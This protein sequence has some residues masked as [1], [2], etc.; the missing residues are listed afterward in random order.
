[1]S[2]LPAGYDNEP[3]GTALCLGVFDGV[4][5]GHQALVD[6]CVEAA[7][8]R[9]LM[10]QALSFDPHPAAFFGKTGA[11][12]LL[13]LPSRRAELLRDLGLAN[14]I[15]ARFDQAFSQQTPEQF[16]DWLANDLQAQLVVTGPDYR[17]GQ[18]RLGTIKTLQQL[19][20]NRFDTLVVDEVGGEGLRYRSSE[21]RQALQ[22]GDLAR[23]RLLTGRDFDFSGVVVAGQGRGRSLGFATANLEVD[24]RQMLPAD[25]VY[26]LRVESREIR[27]DGVMNLGRAPT[28]RGEQGQRIPEVH[29]LDFE[30]DLYGKTLRVQLVE[31]LRPERR[32]DH[33]EALQKQ[34]STDVEA[35]RKVLG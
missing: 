13:T 24:A 7:S 29:L 1:M 23:V 6:H 19:G 2:L 10:P 30:G 34:I 20:A 35:A 25:G 32:F 14:T 17:F 11:Q 4:H 18:K 12:H 22:A 27:V 21:V 5:K 9:N 8:A 15:F 28:V 33:L 16:V 3:A 26:A 31:R